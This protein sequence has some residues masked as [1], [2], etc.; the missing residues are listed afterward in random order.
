MS[1]AGNTPS[2][3]SVDQL[4]GRVGDLLMELHYVDAA[5]D[6]FGPDMAFGQGDAAATY[7][8]TLGWTHPYVHTFVR[9]VIGS[10]D[11]SAEVAEELER[12][13]A[14]SRAWARVQMDAF[15]SG[16]TSLHTPDTGALGDAAISLAE[17]AD[18]LHGAIDTDLSNLNASLSHWYGDAKDSFVDFADGLSTAREQQGTLA[19]TLAAG[20]AASVVAIGTARTS[21]VNLLSA[22]A[23]RLD[24]QLAERANRQS[25]E[26]LDVLRIAAPVASGLSALVAGPAGA[27]AQAVTALVAVAVDQIPDT[28]TAD[29]PITSAPSAASLLIEVRDRILDNRDVQFD[30]ARVQT[31][32]RIEDVLDQ[33]GYELLTPPRPELADH[34]VDADTFHHSSSESY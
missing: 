3:A 31:V 34:P 13:L 29:L 33:G 11:R 4:V 17:R 28:E 7:S 9:P 14:A 1:R 25:Q 20:A 21:V 24:L 12:L 8:V 32:D 6:H 5:I 16:L 10:G 18:T 23:D 22:A 27:I 2:W 19:A 15:A 26:V 30:D